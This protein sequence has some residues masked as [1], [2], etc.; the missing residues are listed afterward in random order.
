MDI[1]K[2]FSERLK[3]LM[4][5]TDNMSSQKLAELIGVHDR[6]VNKWKSGK[7]LISY[8]CLIKVADVFNC[9][10]DFLIGR[11][12]KKLDFTIRPAKPFYER[13]REVM[14]ENNVSWYKLVQNTNISDG[15]LYLWKKGATPKVPALIEIA[16]YLNCT[17]DYLVGRER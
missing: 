15:H 17:V 16:D 7:A 14:D 12:Y 10:L 3:E 13:L 8:D 5:Y 2:K 1:M 11:T 9:S 4:F 6:T